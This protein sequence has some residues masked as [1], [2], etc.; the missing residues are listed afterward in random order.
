M[1]K[2]DVSP[3]QQTL[4]HEVEAA[5]TRIADSVIMS[6]L[7]ISERLSAATDSTV[8]LKREDLQ[9]VRSYK[10]RGAFNFMLQL[11]ATERARGVVCASAGNHAQGFARACK[12]LGIQGT[13]FVPKTTPK[14]KIE[15]VRHF[16]GEWVTIEISGS[17]Y[18]DASA[19]AHRF[20]DRNDALLVSAFDDLLTI[21]GQGTVA[22][23]IA[24]QLEVAPDY[25]IV[26][27]GGGGVISGIA[28]YA[29]EHL[30]GTTIIG[31]EPAGA[32]SMIAALKAGRP[33]TLE[34][35]DPFAD[36]TAVKRAGALTYDIVSDLDVDVR[37]VAEG[38]VA[39]EMLDMYQVDGIIAEPSGA[40]ASAA[41]GGQGTGK[42]IAVEPGSTVV[43]LVS[44]GNNDI[45]R[46]PEILERSLVHEGL[47]HYFIVDFPQEPGALRR[48]LNEILGPE[49]DIAM[50]EYVKRSDRETGPAFVGIELGNAEDLPNLLE[51]M[52][53]SQI[54][55][56]RVHQNSPMFRLFA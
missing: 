33:V 9:M 43:C 51:R 47:K 54:E 49:D 20:A 36:G 15:R 45:S 41:I 55:I 40:I 6:P 11:D 44:G 42:P 46:Y 2:K 35:I 13:I 38:A 37:P 25:I 53:S 50:F 52:D 32:A 14:Q 5:A 19:L 8:Y 1:L 7:Q 24:N 27:V 16:G 17:T 23:E 56:E 3:Q 4:A 29:A 31:A 30:P 18:D 22:V 12:E 48:F 39:T 28:A 26:P 10:I 21:A 34:N